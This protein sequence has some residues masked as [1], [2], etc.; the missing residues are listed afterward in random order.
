VMARPMFD[1]ASAAQAAATPVQP[2]Y[3]EVRARVTLTA[4]MR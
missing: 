3:V 4:S 1:V 2:G